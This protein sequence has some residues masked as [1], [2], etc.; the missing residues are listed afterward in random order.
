MQARASNAAACSGTLQSTPY[1]TKRLQRATSAVTASPSRR[2]AASAASAQASESPESGRAAI[3]AA[4]D[5]L[6]A[7]RGT[8]GTL[9]EPWVGARSVNSSSWVCSFTPQNCLEKRCDSRARA[10]RR[11]RSTATAARHSGPSSARGVKNWRA[12]SPAKRARPYWKRHTR[13]AGQDNLR[14]LRRRASRVHQN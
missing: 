7:E 5:K 4:S 6:P 14:F 13:S 12:F 2:L 3:N 11:S 1:P 10:D 9:E 8:G